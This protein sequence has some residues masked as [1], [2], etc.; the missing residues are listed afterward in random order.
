MRTAPAGSRRSLASGSRKEAFRARRSAG[1]SQGTKA[2][3][4]AS[5]APLPPSRTVRVGITN[6][7]FLAA[8]R[9]TSSSAGWSTKMCTRPSAPSARAARALSAQNVDDAELLSR[10]GGLDQSRKR[11][12]SD[13][14]V[15]QADFPA[16]VVDDLDVIRSLG[17]PGVNECLS[18][19]WSVDCGDPQ[20]VLR[21]MSPRGGRER[22]GGKQ[23]G[24]IS[25]TPGRLFRTAS[26]RRIHGT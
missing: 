7:R 6:A 12:P 4:R 25:S 19:A 20:P 10:V 3:S 15:R 16:V 17:N 8:R 5:A 13:R 11:L 18:L 22:A 2:G 9:T 24:P 26:R 23:V 21:A 1:V 14:R